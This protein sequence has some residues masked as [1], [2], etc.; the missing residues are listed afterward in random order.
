MCVKIN[1]N[2]HVTSS[3]EVKNIKYF[4]KPYCSSILFLKKLE[5]GFYK[6]PLGVYTDFLEALKN[7]FVAPVQL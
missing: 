3:T 2:G 1:V 6:A 4:P 5:G 7:I